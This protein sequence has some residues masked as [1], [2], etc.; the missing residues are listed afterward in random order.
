MSRKIWISWPEIDVR[1]SATLADEQ[2]PELCDEF[3]RSLPFGIVQSHPVVSGSSVTMWLPYLSKAPVSVSES[4]VDAP[5][6]RIRLSQAT[7]S[8]LSIQYGVGLEPAKQAVLGIVDEEYVDVILQVGREVWE[9]LFWRKQDLTVH[10]AA[11]EDDGAQPVRTQLSHPLA[12]RLSDAAD[13][14]QLSEPR[15]IT[16]IRQ[17]DVPDAGSFGQYF[18]VWDAAHGLVRDFV[19]NTLYPIYRALPQH[20]LPTVRTIYATVGAQYHATL[21]YHGLADL[22]DFAR[23]FQAVLDGTDDVAVVED[24][25]EQLLRYGNATYGWSHQAFPWYLG[26]QFPTPGAG[27][28]GGRWQP[29]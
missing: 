4:I 12:Q 3:V 17:G 25:L 11:V 6:G 16:R 18:S 20:G 22:S 14:I 7:G 29:S 23:E 15:D 8:K 26:M 27:R 19:V 28:I 10:F 2:N 24:A 5:R 21:K 9:N 13:A 1:V